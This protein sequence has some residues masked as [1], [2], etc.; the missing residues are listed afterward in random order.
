M[1]YRMRAGRPASAQYVEVSRHSTGKRRST[2][3]TAGWTE[4]AYTVTQV[5]EAIRSP[6]TWLATMSRK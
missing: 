4:R 5:W 2:C 3:R 6:A 1:Q